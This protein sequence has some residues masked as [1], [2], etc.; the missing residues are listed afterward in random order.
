MKLTPRR[1]TVGLISAALAASTSYVPSPALAAGGSSNPAVRLIVGY[2]DGADQAAARRTISSMGAEASA[3]QTLAA[4]GAQAIRVPAARSTAMIAALRMDPNVAYVEVD[5]IRKKSDLTPNDPVYTGNHQPELQ[6]VNLPAAWERTTG[7]AVKIAVVD[8]G[9]NAVGDL[10]GAVLRGHDFVN[11]DNYPDDDEGHGTIVASLIAARGNN[12]EGMAGVCWSCQILPVK[13]LNSKGS[14][15]D[16]A[17]AKGIVWAVNS[18]VSVINLSLGGA[19]SSTV[20]AN[21]IRYATL[22]NVLVVAA[23][24]NEHTSKRSYPAAYGD[25]LAVGATTTGSDSRA[26]FSNYNSSSDRWVDVAAPGIVSAMTDDGVYRAGLQGTSFSSPIVAGIAGLVKTQHPGYT[27]WSL[28]R[29][30]VA[31]ARPIGGWTTYGKV[32]ANKAINGSTETGAPY[33]TGISPG[34]WAKVH[35]IVTVTVGGVGDSGSGVRAVDLYADGVWKSYD[36]AAPYQPR[37]DTR[38]RSGTVRLTL[39]V[40]DKAGNA[41]SYDRY[42]WV[43]NVAP[44][45]KVSKAPKNKAKIKG[46]VKVY[47]KASDKSGINRIQLL[48]NGKVVSTHKTAKYPFTFKASKYPKKTTIQVRAYDNAG[49]AKVTPKLYYH[50]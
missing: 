2:K 29:S 32:D 13:V 20:L 11:N 28:Q 18:G 5:Q 21:A 1:I 23:A 7:S 38:G 31:S 10:S 40:T 6:E 43:D 25:V 36:G 35:G 42:I 14:G 9:V 17:I 49:N 27:G 39:R 3:E 45:I 12:N 16:S 37:Y 22:K 46:T 8:T 48:I 50:R 26:S 41:K 47:V 30:I 33:A 19:G 4:L 24:G 34:Q 15:Y 44:S